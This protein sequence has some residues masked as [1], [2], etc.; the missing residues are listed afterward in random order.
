MMLEGA[1]EL[2][3]WFEK[4]KSVFGIS[5]CEEDKNVKFAAATLQG[6]ALTW[7]NAKVATMGLETVNQIP[8]TEMKQLMTA[9]VKVDA[10]IHGL[11]DN[12]KGKV[13]S[14]K[15]ANLN[16]AV[17]MAHKLMEQKSQARD[18][19]ILEGKK[20]KWESFQS[21]N[22]S[23]ESNHKDN[24]RQN[25]Q[26]NQNQGN[27]RAMVTAPTD[28][29]VSSGSLPLCECCFTLHVGLCTIKCHKCGKV[30]HK[31]RY[32]KEKNVAMGANAL[33]ISTCYNCGEQAPH[34]VSSVK[35]HILKKR[36]YLLWTMK[37]EQYLA[38]TD[39]A[40]WEVIL[41]GN[42]EVQ[43]TKDEVGNE[44]EVPPVTVQ[45]ILARTRERKAKST[46]LMAISDEHLARF[47]GIKDAKTLWVALKPDLV[48]VAFVSAKSTISTNELN[49][50]YSV[51]TTTSH[52]SQAQGSS[53]YVDEL[54]FLFF[55]NQ[56]SSPQL[57]NEDLEQI[58]QDDSEEMELKWQM[59][60]LSMRVKRFYKKTRRKLEF[61]GKELVGFD[62]T[63]VECFN[64][65]RR[66]HFAR[67]CKTAR[68]PRNRGRDVGN[69]GYIKRD[70]S[71]R[72]A[73]EGDEKA[74]VVQDG[75]GYD[76]QFSE[77]YVLDVKEEEVT[78]T[79][80]DNRLSDE[81]NSLAN[82][83]FKKDR[84]AKKF[85][86]PN[87]VGKG[88]GHRESRPV[89]NN[90]QRINHQNKFDPTA[91]FTR[92]GRI[93]VS[94]AK[95]KAATS[96]SAAK[97][98]NTARPKQS[99][100]FSNSGSTFHKSHSPIR[101]SFY[102]ATA[103]SKS[104]STKRVNIGGSKAVSVVK[105]NGL[106]VVKNVVPSGN[107]TCLSAKASID[108][109]NLCHRR[110]GHKGKQ[111][112]ATCKAKLMSSISQ[113]LHMLHMDLFGLTSIISTNHKKYCL[114]VTDDFSRFSW[115]FFATKDET[116]KAETVNTACN[117]LNRAL[118]TKHHNKTPYEPLNGRSPRLDFMR[119]FGCPVTIL[120]TLDPLGK[121]EVKLMRDFWLG[122][123]TE[124]NAGPQ[125]TNGNAGTQDN[126]DAGKEV[127][128]Q[129]HIVL[130]LWSSI[131]FTYK[132]SDDKAE[133]DKPKDDTGSKTVVEPVNKE[134]QDYRDELD[135]LMRQEKEASDAADSLKK[136]FEQGCM[137][138]R[139]AA[140]A[141]S[142]S[143]FN[144]VSNPVNAANNSETFSTG[145][146]SSPHPDAFIPDDT[147]LN[148][149]PKKVAQALDDEIWVEAMQD[150]LLQ[151]S[152]QKVWRLVDLPYGKKAIG[153][154]WVYQNKKDE[155]GILVRS[156]AR[157]AAQGHK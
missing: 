147:L 54:M 21:E 125:D 117:V 48:N 5:E 87:N 70:N 78:E 129:H 30:R 93:P 59:A 73:R 35:L 94:A 18:K 109:S 68:N 83:R 80:F 143:S 124:K 130:P 135:K 22:S 138:Q 154:K 37:M 7:W 13:T 150:E 43:M 75:L 133:D 148:M 98:V 118:V 33:P 69:A 105:G 4:T 50:A 79:V 120:N 27:A 142:T 122:N 36:E 31:A 136:E 11:T 16:E 39:Y 113:P 114:V 127:S 14:S 132:S 34:M 67:D 15:P 20:Q 140:K 49:A 88:I 156:K 134:D 131:S 63:K 40:L 121:F 10:Y 137:Y 119:P 24:S 77:K 28:G 57:D 58:D 84:M 2:R 95:P 104:N 112:K 52:S 101:R 61:N 157:L 8:W 6:P 72:P 32:C 126:V 3:R 26:N 100:N 64:C 155:R 97:P 116:S 108:E 107:L 146:P 85:M 99:V 110:L 25:L 74:L 17:R 91:V 71:K 123:Q 151:F 56:S 51:S 102:N 38:H 111:H 152:L 41:N 90:I 153:T 141:G 89:W 62:K 106:T 139:G 42:G 82:D 103:H 60:M 92:S 45:Q 55:A 66:G 115:V 76:S 46:L 81:E 23:G 86:L 128:D 12:I 65:H 29:K 149:E 144:T 9:E 1:V 19:R 44:V 96:I 53:S 47:H 145:R